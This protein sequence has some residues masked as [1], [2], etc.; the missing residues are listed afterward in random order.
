MAPDQRYCINCGERRTGGGLRDALPRTQAAA[1]V[2]TAAPRARMSP[3][4]SL[5]AGVATL[6]LALGVGVLIGRAGDNG[7]SKA[8]APQVV[9][10]SAGTAG[11]AGA[12]GA[13]TAAASTSSAAKS[14]AA[15]KKAKHAAKAKVSGTSSVDATAKK[16]GV[17]LPPKVV[18]VGQ[19]CAKGTKGCQGGKFT[20]NYFG[21]G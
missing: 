7:T 9:T 1:P 13:T 11:A 12:D 8:A 15:K 17:K 10:V 18:K 6:L 21:G 20:G 2:A 5:I 4:T 19:A 16:N 14:A 3:N